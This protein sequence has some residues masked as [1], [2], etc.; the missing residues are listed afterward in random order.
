VVQSL[1]PS[2]SDRWGQDYEE[3]SRR[4]LTDQESVYIWADDIRVNVRLEDDG[5]PKQCLLVLMGATADGR[6]VPSTKRRAAAA[7]R[8]R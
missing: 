1:C 3:W 6:P 2:S 8:I 5:T 7:P 4:D